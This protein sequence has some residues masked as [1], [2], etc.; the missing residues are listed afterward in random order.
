[1]TGMPSLA[2][3][4]GALLLTVGMLMALPN[5]VL[6]TDSDGDLL[7]DGF[8]SS[9]G[10]TSPNDPDT[11]GD[12][13][14]DSAEDNDH[15]DLGNLGEQRFG[16]DPGTR[17]TDGDGRKD[18][19]EDSDGDGLSDALE[20]DQRRIPA[21]LRPTLS[22]AKYDVSPYKSGCQTTH[23]KAGLTICR[24]GPASA[25]RTVAL[26]GDSHAMMMLSPI[27]NVAEDKGWRLITLVKKACPPVLG[28]HNVAQKWLDDGKT[29]RAWRRKAIDW[30][31]AHPPDDIIISHSD[32]YGISNLRGRRLHGTAVATA[33]R[34]GMKRT[35][36]A[37]PPSAEVLLVTDIPINRGNPVRCLKHHPDDISSCSTRKEPPAG[38]TVERALEQAARARGATFRSIYNKVCTYDPCPV[39]QGDILVWR[40]RG[41]FTA[42]FSDQLTPAFR[43]LLSNV[44]GPTRKRR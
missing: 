28:I 38:R 33:W 21:G 7:S 23:G 9:W 31:A 32:R 11:D 24:F 30:L 41:H 6:G 12:G 37:M 20:Q 4:V 43:T 35:L 36:A 14:V 15:D 18:G 29:C 5:A 8:E 16:T 2:R 26:V 17:D 27:K 40:D 19:L 22:E 10:L 3:T 1:M 39:I 34:K 44:I 13:V 25:A 42:T